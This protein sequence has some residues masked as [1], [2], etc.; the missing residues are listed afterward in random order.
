M[1]YGFDLNSASWQLDGSTVINLDRMRELDSVTSIGLRKTLCR[2]AEELSGAATDNSFTK[3]NMYCDQT[4]SQSVTVSGLTKWRALLV[5]ENEWW[6]GALKGFLI[7]WHEWGFPGVETE[8]VDYL[9]ELSLRGNS[10]GKAVRRACP[11]SGPLTP[12]ELQ[13]LI[14]WASNAFYED[15]LDLTSYAYFLT[16]VF[17]GR[18]AVQIR[19]LRASDLSFREDT[20]G[21]DYIVRFPRAKQQRSGFRQDFNPLSVPEDLYLVLDNQSKASQAYVEQALGKKLP[22]ALKKEIPVFL[23]EDRVRVLEDIQDLEKRLKETPDML[24]MTEKK[25]AETLQS[26][27]VKNK[28]KSERT[29]E[30]INFTSRRFRYTKGT[31]LARRGISGVAL[32]HALDHS[33]TQNVDVYTANTEEMAVQIDKVM[34]PILAPL[35]QAFAGVLIDSERDALRAND[36]HS[37]VKNTNANTIGNC[38]TH[39]FCA[40]G[41]RACYTCVNFQPLRDAPHQEVLDVVI[42]ERSRQVSLGIS[43][44]VIQAT[45]RLLLAVQQVVLLCNE[46]KQFGGKKDV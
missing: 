38:G 6:M 21:H 23:A 22:S 44:S 1:G 43:S 33:D 27:S 32:A 40:S 26:V 17:T 15:V 39:A 8:V 36:P 14:E 41:Y 30:F 45:D 42:E 34:A 24:H 4:G 18:R 9:E 13:A 3:F 19:S 28:A 25:A 10:K 31:N 7:A 11:Y 2:Y 5:K 29:G 37:R 35:A 12:I 20:N 46:A 16:L